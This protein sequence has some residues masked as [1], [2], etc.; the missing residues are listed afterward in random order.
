[1]EQ[2]GKVD[3]LGVEEPFES[4]RPEEDGQKIGDGSDKGLEW[5]KIS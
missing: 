4:Q 5:I 2:F 1:M 3:F